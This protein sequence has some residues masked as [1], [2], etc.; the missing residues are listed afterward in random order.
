MTLVI[1]GDSVDSDYIHY[2]GYYMGG[3]GEQ[4]LHSDMT[5]H[6]ISANG[7]GPSYGGNLCPFCQL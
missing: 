3:G 5:F 6:F 4:E 1:L 7:K 2:W